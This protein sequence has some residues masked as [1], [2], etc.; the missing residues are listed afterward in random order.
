M[1]MNCKKIKKLNKKIV[2]LSKRKKSYDYE[3]CL[4]F[5]VKYNAKNRQIINSI[6][7]NEQNHIT[8]SINL[9]TFKHDSNN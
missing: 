5:F 4:I 1:I 9:S 2:K 3:Y 7:A 8:N 6:E